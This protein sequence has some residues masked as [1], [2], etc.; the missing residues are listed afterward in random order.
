MTNAINELK[1]K[2]GFGVPQISSSRSTSHFSSASNALDSAR[3]NYSNVA[4]RAANAGLREIISGLIDARRNHKLDDDAFAEVME[5][6]LA[7]F[8]ENE[9]TSAIENAFG[10]RMHPFLNLQLG[11]KK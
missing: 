1:D 9:V 3:L 6:V 11:G 7:H 10:S 8:I 5:I 2:F 4:H